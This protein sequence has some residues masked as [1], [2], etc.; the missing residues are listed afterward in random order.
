M[1]KWWDEDMSDAGQGMFSDPALAV[2]LA[3][4]PIQLLQQQKV[5]EQAARDARGGFMK[6][7]MNDASSVG[8][9]LDGALK[10]V[11]V[12][13]VNAS[14]GLKAL[15]YPV[16]K[17]ATGMYWAYS[18]GVSQPLSTLFL[19]AATGQG[20]GQ[21]GPD[22]V[23]YFSAGD[24]AKSWH[25]ANDISPAQV[26]FNA[27]NTYN[28]TDNQGALSFL[29]P[30][31][32]NLDK[33]EQDQI[34]RQTSKFI[35]D[36][37]YWRNKQ[38]WTY[39]AGTG[40]LDFMTTL[41]LDPTYAGL[42]VAGAT[43]KGLRTVA[44]AG[45]AT[46]AA[47]GVSLLNIGADKAANAITKGLSKT[48]E[49]ATQGKKVQGFFDWAGKQ[50]SPWAIAQHSIWGT[51]RRTN[52]ARYQL[53]QVLY[54]ADDVEKPLIM[55]FAM[56]D[57][58]AA[59]QLALKNGDLMAQIGRMSDNRQLVDSIKY[60]PALMSHF[61][62]EEQAGRLAPSYPGGPGIGGTSPSTLAN[63]LV[64]APYPRPS[65]PGPRQ[66]GWD[67][68]YGN[69]Q[70]KANVY[71]SAA[72]DI[73]KG[74]NGVRPMSGAAATSFADALRFDAWREGRL[75]SLD[76]QLGVMEAKGG[77]HAEVLGGLTKHPDQFS[78][79]EANLFG[80]TKSL[81][82]MGAVGVRNTEASANAAI[83]S[84]TAD[85]NAIA[86]S[87]T[88]NGAS[89]TKKVGGFAS[90]TLRTGFYS[91]PVRVVQSFGDRLP[92]T[93]VNHNDLDAPERV[94]DML[95]RVPG[96]SRDVRAGMVNAYSAAPDKVSRSAVL[97]K[98][99]QDV[100][101]HM[102]QGKNLSYDAAKV[103]S[104]MIETGTTNAYNKL[105]G[106]SVPKPQMFSAAENAA[107]THRADMYE[108]GEGWI[109]SPLAKTQLSYSEP[110]LDVKELD[111]F[112]SRNSGYLQS[113]HAAGGKM[114]DGVR[115]VSDGL[116][117]VWKAATLLRPGYVV[118][119]PSEEMAASAIK[120]G[121]MSSIMDSA[122]GGKN[123]AL[124]RK[125]QLKAVVGKDSY[126]SA[127]GTKTRLKIVDPS[128]KAT[129]EELK[130]PTTRLNVSDAWPVVM[131]RIGSEKSL[132]SS[133][134]SKISK[135][136]KDKN[137]D[138]AVLAGLKGDLADHQDIIDEFTDY[139][140]ELL[141]LATDSKGRRIGEGLIE[142]NGNVVPQAF[143]KEWD[144][145]ISRDQLSSDSAM[146]TMFARSESIDTG[147]LIKTGAW[148]AIE[149]DDPNYMPSLLDA[150]NKQWGQDDLFK[151]VAGD[152]SLKAAKAWLRTPD[153]RI[154][155]SQMGGHGRDSETLLRGIKDTLGQYTANA[156][157]LLDKISKGETITA[158]E[159]RGAI[160]HDDLQPVHGEEVRGLTK[161]GR[162][163]TAFGHVDNLIEKSFRRLGSIPTD[164]M[165]RHPVYL[166]AQEARMRQ[167]MDDE[168]SY[169]KSIG[170]A[171]DTID[172]KKYNAMLKKS[173]TL[174]RKDISQV[175]Y[176]PTR[177]TATQALRFIA[178][179]LSA[180]IDGL[181]RWGG[182]VAEKPQFVST[183]AKVYNAP[184]AATMVT[185]QYG[186]KVDENG[187]A[188]TYDVDGKVIGKH[189]VSIQNRTINLKVPPGARGLVGRLT[190]TNGQN[191]P[192]KI[193]AL[194]TILPGDPWWNPGTGPVVQ[195]AAS[196]IAKKNPAMGD[197]LQWAKVLPYG[198]TG[199]ADSLTPKYIKEAWTSYQ[200]ASGNENSEDFRKNV[201]AEYQ[202]QVADH[203]N[204]GP[205][206]D[207]DLAE[208]N[209]KKF[210]YLKAFT[211]WMTPA[212]MQT[213]PLT[214]TPYQ[215]YI[216]QYRKMQEVDPKNADANFLQ[217]Y[218][219][220]Y[221]VFTA[222]L[223]KSIGIA[224]TLSAANVAKGE[225]DLISNSVV[226]DDGLV[227]FIVG[228][229]YN[230]GDFSSSAYAAE[231]GMS[232]GGQKA[233]GTTSVE[234]ALT[235]AQRRLGWATYGKLI[236]GVDAALIRSGFHSYTQSGAD[237]FL[238]LKQQIQQD[239]GS[240][241]PAWL[242]DFS[243]T[244]TNAVPK[245]IDA[246]KQLVQDPRL[247]DDPMRQDIP[248]L[249]QYLA[250]RDVFKTVLQG[251]G[252]SKLSFDVAGRPIGNNQDIGQSWR[253]FQTS[254]VA[255][256]TMFADV[257]N[258]YLSN[259]D[260]Q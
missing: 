71:R 55:R 231:K 154:H 226:N 161:Q 4:M 121:L 78:P 222:S 67:A 155:L 25:K 130:L 79:G 129:T 30:G 110:L 164:I 232:F 197:F 11:G 137:H 63:Q 101:A 238:L 17:T 88:A 20:S 16:D 253:T 252:S 32:K 239:V 166:R 85:R 126:A 26:V 66:A 34:K 246:L 108:D 68:L 184:V 203:A 117:N 254:L 146:Q 223:S 157:V 58:T 75:T 14:N 122:H 237:N 230:K 168:L 24:W 39:T 160:A 240:K 43:V 147:R 37:D 173:D 148:T 107:T 52:P 233:R 242:D 8:H 18:N 69:L 28:A 176:D 207:F 36:T 175:V 127:V 6:N 2:Q 74:Q 13:P 209:A 259:D 249:T 229:V 162:T 165:S 224:P 90:R 91:V 41:G 191:V 187:Y 206:P 35:N 125:Q 144:N 119:A 185:D 53:S 258:R 115:D 10:H 81:Y 76:T 70:K 136:E 227:P 49:Q 159:I 151:L 208:K 84:K 195:I 158:A 260:L 116:S 83:A 86:V 109:V 23:N 177:T 181:E 50:D 64:E 205:P 140:H 243:T 59:Q 163:Q 153:G 199:F 241:Y 3:T 46:K 45:E 236:N 48:P 149:K 60:D 135:M 19:M 131:D 171:G 220:D 156:P 250:M 100:V 248:Y 204:G 102:A 128:L 221:F 251:R 114:Y 57:N 183:A 118:R 170:N 152:P 51:G 198:P 247:R 120:F 95:K 228:D 132:H 150:L 72:G 124:N 42:K 179:F 255:G 244:N 94:L 180:H 5:Q 234:D 182:L 73:L 215:F 139:S 188:D 178:P 143:S 145:P 99:H 200:V 123:W 190:G 98:I 97:K 193:Q 87:K 133:L 96:L 218:G 21:G 38:G 106:K 104:D 103:I 134:A 174:A 111:R 29:G 89:L 196:Q 54:G 1:S 138:P 113:L 7:I 61:M 12:G 202:R 201:L 257:Y 82:R 211:S 33:T 192:I 9:A 77:L 27:E 142:H 213:T 186:A 212:Q 167:L 225:K 245:R 256:N 217:R 15:W 93:L 47:K 172:P 40:A 22:A 44:V 112:L 80:T 92:T 214:G 169:Q 62:G 216:D 65:T 235:D 189:F 210:S 31:G 141:R 56:G 105:Q 219:S 194:N